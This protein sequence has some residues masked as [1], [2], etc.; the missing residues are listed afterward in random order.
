MGN[1]PKESYE[2]NDAVY[3]N[4]DHILDKNI[5]DELKEKNCYSQHAGWNF[6]GYIWHDGKKF[7]E[8]VWVYG[9]PQEVIENEDIGELI[10]NVCQKY[11]SN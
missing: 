11:G 3:S 10:E 4:F 9:D 2:T 7:K 1:I 6:C 8:E 5:V